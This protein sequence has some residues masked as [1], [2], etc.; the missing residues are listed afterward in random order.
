MTALTITVTGTDS[1]GH[2]AA[3]SVTVEVNSPAAERPAAR[4]EEEERPSRRMAAAG[5]QIGGFGNEH[6]HQKIPETAKPP[7]V[8]EASRSMTYARFTGGYR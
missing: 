5:P 1:Q 7:V 3:D 8:T 4:E 6:G 2:T